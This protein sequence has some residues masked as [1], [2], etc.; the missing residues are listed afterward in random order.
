M[1]F[2]LTGIKEHPPLSGYGPAR[3]KHHEFRFD[4]ETPSGAIEVAGWYQRE[5]GI[6]FAEVAEVA[7]HIVPEGV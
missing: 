5:Y 4:A 7:M 2:R 1:H 6:Q 3:I